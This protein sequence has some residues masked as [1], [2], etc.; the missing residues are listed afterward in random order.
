MKDEF[1]EHAGEI[2]ALIPDIHEFTEGENN[3]NIG[4]GGDNLFDGGNFLG[5]DIQ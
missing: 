3:N 4:D 5:T 1:D 2:V